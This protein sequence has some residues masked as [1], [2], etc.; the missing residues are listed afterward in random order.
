MRRKY[1]DMRDVYDGGVVFNPTFNNS[2]AISWR[3]V[4]LVD[5]TGVAV[6]NHNSAASDGQTLSRRCLF[7]YEY[8]AEIGI[9]LKI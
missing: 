2:S 9:E 3:S 8:F 5:D 1:G 7:L 4:L 6:E